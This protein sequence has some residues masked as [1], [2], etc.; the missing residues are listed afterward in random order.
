M[1][2]GGMSNL[3]YQP[4]QAMTTF[5]DQQDFHNITKDEEAFLPHSSCSKMLPLKDDWI[6]EFAASQLNT[7][8]AACAPAA[9]QVPCCPV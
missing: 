8:T 4:F 1:P 6:S 5:P 9:A 7:P 2:H 3:S